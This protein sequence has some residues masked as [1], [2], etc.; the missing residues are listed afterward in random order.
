MAKLI[1]PKEFR[2]AY[3]G[4]R[5]SVNWETN[6]ARFHVWMRVS[7]MLDPIGPVIYKNP[8]KE[9]VYNGPGYFRTRHL[10]GRKNPSILAALLA[11]PPA[12][13]VAAQADYVTRERERHA[14]DRDNA[15]EQLR[16]SAK[17]LGFEL[18]PIVKPSAQVGQVE[19]RHDRFM[20]RV[21]S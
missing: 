20:A 18:V 3:D 16:E 19:L 14:Q 10:D 4:N 13:F 15:I 2:V 6:D 9:V 1:A 8:P 7:G 12:D 5:Y 21:H 17:A 11:I